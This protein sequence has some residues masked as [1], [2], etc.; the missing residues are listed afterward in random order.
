[1]IKLLIKGLQKAALTSFMVLQ[2][3]HL[4]E[5]KEQNSSSMIYKIVLDLC[6]VGIQIYN[7]SATIAPLISFW[8][9]FEGVLKM[10]F[11]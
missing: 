7:I 5:R 10:H 11:R 3:V 4:D 8:K 1:M 6:V 2:G 9:K